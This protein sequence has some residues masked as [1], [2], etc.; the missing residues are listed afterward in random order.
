MRSSRGELAEAGHT[1]SVFDGRSH[2][3]GNCHTVRDPE[4][5]VM[6]H[7]YGPHIFHTQFEHVWHYITRF[8][9]MRPY[10]HRVMAT[11]GEQVYSLPVNLLTIN[12]FFGTAMGPAEAAEFLQ[13]RA[14]PVAEPV[15]FE[16]QG[17]S[18]VGRELYEAFFAGYTRKQWGTDPRDLP[19][20]ILQRLPV[21]FNYDDSYFN[22]PFQGIPANGYTPIVE[23][24]L[25]HTGDHRA[26]VHPAGLVRRRTRSITSCGRDPSTTSSTTST[27]GSRTGR[28]TSSARRI[29]VT[30]RVARS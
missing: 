30:C 27:V 22:H 13:A 20:S 8:G 4:T 19:A 28:S 1:V 6:V 9:D 16:D 7:V 25:D 24:I 12:Q 29:S 11:V 26:P 2:V 3:A 14:E 15:S 17:L 21:R 18:F 5:D 10:R 23:A